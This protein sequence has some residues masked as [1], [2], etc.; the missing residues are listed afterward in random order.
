MSNGLDSK[1]RL[2]TAKRVRRRIEHGGERFWRIRDFPGL[3]PA[4]VART[5]S[6]LTDEGVLERPRRGLYYRPRSTRFGQ[7]R[8]SPSAIANATLS[9]EVQPAGLTAANVLGLTT[10]NVATAQL[11]TSANNAPPWPQ[12]AQI[13]ARR[14][15]ARQK[16]SHRE[17]ALLE[18]LRDR[19][20]TSDLDF[21]AT[22]RRL[23][24]ELE[25]P[26]AFGRI[27][28]AAVHEPPRVRAILGALGQELGADQRLLQQL[29]RSLNPLSKFDFGRLRPLRHAAEW[30]AK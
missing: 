4:A 11:V 20:R 23:F 16:L 10:Q 12:P 19:G 18:V 13:R 15:Q 22:R 21:R 26:E 25:D 24:A 14:P 8:P 9:A 29:R 30:Q 5:L 27:A 3:P 28:R 7:S 6:R 1:K 2:S 17:A